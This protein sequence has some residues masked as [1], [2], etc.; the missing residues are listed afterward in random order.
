MQIYFKRI[1]AAVAATNAASA[2]LSGGQRRCMD[3]A[4]A[5]RVAGT[6]WRRKDGFMEPASLG[7]YRSV[8][9]VRKRQG[10][11]CPGSHAK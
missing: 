10:R 4:R 11:Q 2:A 1:N 3:A 8:S 7:D 6:P 9:R 5:G